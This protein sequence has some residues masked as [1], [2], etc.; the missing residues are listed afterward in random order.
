MTSEFIQTQITKR[1]IV[2]D[3]YIIKTTNKHFN[4]DEKKLLLKKLLKINS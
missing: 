1:N 2:F 3:N 4:K